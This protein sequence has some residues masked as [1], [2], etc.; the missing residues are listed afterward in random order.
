[1]NQMN[2]RAFILEAE[3]SNDKD[4]DGHRTDSHPLLKALDARGIEGEIRYFR[5]GEEKVLEE[6]L[7]RSAGIVLSR[8]NPGNLP[9]TDTY[10]QFLERLA[11]AG[12]VVQ[13]HPDVMATLSM[14]DLFYKLRGTGL[15]PH[16]TDFYR[17]PPELR[18]RFPL[19]LATG[20]RVLKKNFT[21]T[22]IGVWKVDRLR[23][24]A[25]KCVQASDYEER[26]FSNLEK[27]YDFLEPVFLEQYSEH[28][29]YFRNRG[30]IL[31][32]PYLPGISEGEVR[33]FL[34]HDK[35][36]YI[37]HKKPKGGGFSATLFSGAEYSADSN[38][39]RWDDVVAQTLWGLQKI[40][41][42]LG[43]KPLPVI[44]SIDSI[45]GLQA[46]GRQSY[47]FSDVNASCVGFSSPDI[48]HRISGMIAD[49]LVREL[50][51]TEEPKREDVEKAE[52]FCFA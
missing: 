3:G 24:G 1:M 17:T 12:L 16:D 5:S 7:I 18:E 15:V 30:G 43:S 39:R 19:A 41:K 27:F 11:N 33:V 29:A 37:L 8:I 25:V 46:D 20:T 47:Y 36:C 23:S 10:W 32:M 40:R 45:P 21:S 9:D 38:L 49:Q 2:S 4:S 35:P 6:E 52:S 28:P 42:F 50:E 51:G 14:K 31:D 48:V 22:G 13:T 44:W 34:I 26:I